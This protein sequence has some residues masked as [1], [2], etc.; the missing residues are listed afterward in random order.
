VTGDDR[1]RALTDAICALTDA[2]VA[3]LR[4][5]SF[6]VGGFELRPGTDSRFL[7]APEARGLAVET[8]EAVGFERVREA[9]APPTE[10]VY[11]GTLERFERRTGLDRPV[12][13]D[14]TVG[15]LRCARTD[16]RWSFAYLAGTAYVSTLLPGPPTRVV[17]GEVLAAAKLH[18]GTR[19]ALGDVLVAVPNL[20]FDAVEDHLHRGDPTALERRLD[21][22]R[23][24]V[25][26]GGLDHLVGMPLGARSAAPDHRDRLLGFLRRS[27]TEK[28][29]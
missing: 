29:R 1:T 4:D 22:A 17:E 14:V 5:G 13:V 11:V 19:R 21:A 9:N 3:F 10:T 15:G 16:A 8:L 28:E 26:E 18:R 7:L 12:G 2:D 6:G 27:K 23:T 20:D 25:A 24:F